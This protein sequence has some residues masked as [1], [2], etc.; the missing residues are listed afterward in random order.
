LIVAA[1]VFLAWNAWRALSLQAGEEEAQR[2]REARQRMRQ[3]ALA[4]VRDGVSRWS[5][6]PAVPFPV[7]RPVLPALTVPAGP[8]DQEAFLQVAAASGTARTARL[9]QALLDAHDADKPFWNLLLGKDALARGDEAAARGAFERTAASPFDARLPDGWS[10]RAEG[11]RLLALIHARNGRLPEAVAGLRELATVPAPEP[12]PT[13][14][15]AWWPA[16]GSRELALWAA[17]VTMAWQA[18]GPAPLEPAWSKVL[19][20]PVLALPQGQ[21]GILFPAG[22]DGKRLER[23]LAEAAGTAHPLR[24]TWQDDGEPLPGMTGLRVHWLDA[25]APPPPMGGS[26]LLTGF[27]V[28]LGLLG[29]ALL[30]QT[31]WR[32]EAESRW[33]SEQERFYRQAAHDLKTPLATLRT[34]A[35]T[36]SLGRISGPEQAERYCRSMI[37]EADQA[38]GVVD[39]MLLA[40][41]LRGGL[42]EPACETVFPAAVLGDL[43][44]RLGPRLEGW[45]RTLSLPPDPAVR[46]D[47]AMFSRAL[48]NLLEN[49]LR[50]AAAGREMLLVVRAERPETV[51]ILVGDRGPGRVVGDRI[52]GAAGTVGSGLG[53]ELAR[54]IL[55]RHG[56]TLI[57]ENRP[58]GGLLIVTRWPAAMSGAPVP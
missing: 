8:V 38:A 14:F 55:S 58:G 32:R 13:S 27:V 12:P 56:G 44:D 36:L 46:A 29:I 19:D 15:D 4:F 39:G 43:L 7:P 48:L 5:T 10:L 40:A 47:P 26:R 3:A 52:E 50:H 17:L 18:S 28:A 49:V 16:T 53:L 22:T 24:L 23:E 30:L 31:L 35:E 54:A 9:L 45:T 37:R 2:R 6:L 57:P 1:Q 42:V 25:G 20:E 51:D 41:R 34:L 11:A 33:W 21:G